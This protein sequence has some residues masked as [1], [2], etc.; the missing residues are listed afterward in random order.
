MN[1]E[2][3]KLIEK[4]FQGE[5]LYIERGKLYH[6]KGEY[7][8]AI[9]E[10]KKAIE[11][12]PNNELAHFEI[13]NVYVK[14]KKDSL[15]ETE[16]NKALELNPHLF[17][18]ALELGRF[19]HYRQR[20][21]DLALE[22]LK[23]VVI[24][25]R[26]NWE[27]YF[28]MGKIYKQKRQYCPAME[29]FK[30]A[31]STA[32][33]NFQVNFELGKLYRD[34][35]ISY[36]AIEEF[37]KALSAGQ[38]RSDIF[39]KNKA[40]NEIEITEKRLIL[41]SKVRA[42]VAMITNKCNLRCIMCNIWKSSWQASSKTMSEILK[43]FPYIEDMVWEG[44]EV[45]IMEGFDDVLA[46]ASRYSHLKQVIFTN[47]LLF[48][49]KIV[50]KLICGRVD[51]VFSIDGATKETYEYIRKGGK[52]ERLLKNLDM[53]KLAKEKSGGLIE[54][55][56]NSII[57]KSNYH[58]IEKLIDFAKEYNFNA[59]TLTPIRGD[60][61]EE[62]IFEKNNIVALEYI[63]KTI[64]KV[65]KKAYGYGMILNNWLPGMQEE[66]SLLKKEDSFSENLK[67][68]ENLSYKSTICNAPWQRLVIDSEGQV[69]PFVFCLNK[70]AGN[71]DRDSLEEI[72]NNDTIQE[73]R[74]RIINHDYQ[75]LCQ[76]ECISGQV[77]EKIRDII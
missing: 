72:W 39:L 4:N 49:E 22:N 15:A 9:E 43:L 26:N 70:W 54:T 41:E 37:R 24:E 32:R 13:G 71:T 44:G 68:T 20:R 18:A 62:N 66:C 77:A 21:L 8:L 67:S 14:T 52:F 7:I 56:F 33:D 69:R 10:L 45:L 60:F 38:S 34:L 53:I 73:Y 46:E 61:G 28:E 29:S 64:P 23:R 63:E 55:H 76:P 65:V 1:I 31:S 48:N 30:K 58:E 6:N 17:S 16:Y 50:D 74:R 40:L 25:D 36:L 3:F 11:I 42:I 75:G 5:W 19:Y 35:G 47:G 57:M 2:E 27:A 12:N 51:I 59:V